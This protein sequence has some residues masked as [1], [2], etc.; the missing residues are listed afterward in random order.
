MPTRLPPIP[1]PLLLVGV[2]AIAGDV[3]YMVGASLERG[4][5]ELRLWSADQPV[6]NK[7]LDEYGHGKISRADLLKVYQPVV[8]YLPDRTCVGMKPR[9]EALGGEDTMCFDKAGTRLL[10]Y[11][12]AGS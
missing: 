11:Y 4:R 2:A 1:V 9:S 10:F 6:V 7:A 5:S 12:N 3:G 8:I